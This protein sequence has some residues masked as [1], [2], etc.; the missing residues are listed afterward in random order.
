M[1]TANGSQ[2]VTDNPR[3]REWL[4]TYLT[5][6]DD[7]YDDIWIDCALRAVAQ[8]DA[9]NGGVWID[10]PTVGSGYQMTALDISKFLH[11]DHLL[12]NDGGGKRNK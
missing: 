1:L 7:P 10:V 4:F 2:T 11:I 3:S 8:I 12:N 6:C 5:E 9:G